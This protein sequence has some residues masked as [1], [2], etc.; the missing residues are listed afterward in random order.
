MKIK[1][2]FVVR[3]IID[4]IVA[5]P[6]GDLLKE[7]SGIITLNESGRFLWELLETETTEEELVEKLIEK[8]HVDEERAKTDVQ[9]FLN[10]LREKEI[11]IE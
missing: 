6:T 5:V 1:E 11:I 7:A 8:Y 2:G 10:A 4:T 3:K 9:A